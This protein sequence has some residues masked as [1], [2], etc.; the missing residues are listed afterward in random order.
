MHNEVAAGSRSL[1][2]GNAS[3]VDLFVPPLSVN[4]AQI[5]F[6]CSLQSNAFL[7]E[8]TSERNTAL[9]TNMYLH[10]SIRTE[11]IETLSYPSFPGIIL[12]NQD[13]CCA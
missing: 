5:K 2:Y 8:V 1:A 3:L 6:K 13:K 11:V 4:H 10:F 12:M 7:S 9:I